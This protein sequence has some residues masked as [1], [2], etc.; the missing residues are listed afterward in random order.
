MRTVR[1]FSGVI[2]AL[3]LGAALSGC[4][5]SASIGSGPPVVAKADLQKDITDRLTKAGQTPQ[6]VTCSEDL[7]G[8]VDKT[9]RCEV[10]LSDTNAIEPI[11]KTT[12][13]DGTTV[14]YE[15]TPALNKDQLQQQVGRLMKQNDMAADSVT[16]EGGLEGVVGTETRCTIDA[17]GSSTETSVKVT[18]V[19]GLLMNFQIY[20][21]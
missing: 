15:M 21:A 19:N 20:P 12:K 13:V 3:A 10:V 1:L 2:G 17:D 6:S 8:E 5:V 11:V 14:S 16:C 4:H 18:D 9:T 7:V